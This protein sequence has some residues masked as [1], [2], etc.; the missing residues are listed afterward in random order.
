MHTWEKCLLSLLEKIYLPLKAKNIEWA[1]IGSCATALQKISVV[2]KDIDILLK[3]KKDVFYFADLLTEFLVEKCD[4]D[5]PH[6]NLWQSSKKLP[7]YFDPPNPKEF[8]WTFG[9]WF[10]ED[11]KV[12]VAHIEAPEN[13]YSTKNNVSGIWEGG[14]EI[15]AYIKEINFKNYSI[16]VVPLEIQLETNFNR[17]LTDRTDKILENFNKNGFDKKLLEFALSEKNKK[18]DNLKNK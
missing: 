18:L 2:P 7:I 12:E 6:N 5:E 3:S 13:F 8:V 14:S 1:I 4:V 16:P 9:R 17:K 11:F 15:W 10:I